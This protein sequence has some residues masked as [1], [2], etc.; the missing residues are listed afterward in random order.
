MIVKRNLLAA[1]VSAGLALAALCS[2]ETR[3]RAA[4]DPDDLDSGVRSVAG[5]FALIEKNYA[6]PVS[7]DR[8]FYQGAIP[9]ML[10]TL[11]P[12]SNFLNPSE[13][14]D[15]QRKQRAQY[16]GVGMLISV[17][18]GLVVA[19]EPFPGS[20][21]AQAGLRRGDGIVEVDGK[22]VKGMDSALVA[23]LLRGPRN[24]Q[25]RVTVKREGVAEPLVMVVTRGEII[26]NNQVDA[27]WLKPGVVYLGI[28]TF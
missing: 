15:M 12:H 14:A 3:V 24:T 19:M 8:A 6:E 13:Y 25:V 21:A 18:D 4:S 7:A 5:V 27:Y 22:N 16:F 10:S 23:D 9:G 2:F 28:A 11:D 20:P 26:T 17:D 1:L